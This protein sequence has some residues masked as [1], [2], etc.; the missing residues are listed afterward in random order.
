MTTKY[1]RQ[2]HNEEAGSER[3]RNSYL[4]KTQRPCRY[5]Q[6]VRDTDM[7]VRSKCAFKVNSLAYQI[8][9]RIQSDFAVCMITNFL[10]L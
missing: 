7:V 3:I 5:N 10:R 6:V 2:V 8:H 9:L 4:N 1:I